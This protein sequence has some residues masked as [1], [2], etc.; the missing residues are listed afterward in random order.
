MFFFTKTKNTL[1]SAKFC[2]HISSSE[3]RKLIERFSSRNNK[4]DPGKRDPGRNTTSSSP[5]PVNIQNKEF[6]SVTST[7]TSHVEQAES[8][9]VPYNSTPSTSNSSSSRRLRRHV[10]YSRPE[11]SDEVKSESECIIHFS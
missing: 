1:T 9:I 11:F 2:I 8:H 7:P 5:Y 6:S 10:V 4:K 3:V